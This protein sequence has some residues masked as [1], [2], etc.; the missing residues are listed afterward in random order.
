LLRLSFCSLTATAQFFVS[1]ETL[2]RTNAIVLQCFASVL[3][4]IC[5][6]VTTVFLIKT[7]LFLR[8]D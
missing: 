6:V 5:K 3:Q 2:V 1:G 4:T 8:D 7:P